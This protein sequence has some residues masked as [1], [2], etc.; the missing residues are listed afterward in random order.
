LTDTSGWGDS[1]AT[2]HPVKGK[3]ADEILSDP[4]MKQRVDAAQ[5]QLAQD[6]PLQIK[7]ISGK[8][9]SEVLQTSGQGVKVAPQ[10]DPLSNYDPNNPNLPKPNT[11]IPLRNLNSAATSGAIPSD[12]T[13]QTMTK[14]DLNNQL[15]IMH[16]DQALTLKQRLFAAGYLGQDAIS[17]DSVPDTPDITADVQKG[18]A[19]LID[20]TAVAN[21]KITD[22]SQ[23]ISLDE[24]LTNKIADQKTNLDNAVRE[25]Y[26]LPTVMENV[27]G[28]AEKMLGRRLTDDE[29]N[30]V[31]NATFNTPQP[32]HRPEDLVVHGGGADSTAIAFGK[33]LAKSYGLTVTQDFSPPSA[34]PSKEFTKGLGVMLGGDPDQ[35]LALHQWANANT[36]DGKLFKVAESITTD[37]LGPV[38]TPEGDSAGNGLTTVG[39]KLVFNDGATKPVISGGNFYDTTDKT[40]DLAKFMAAIRRPGGEAAYNWQG[41][42][43]ARGAYGLSDATWNTYAQKVGVD[44]GNPT[45][46]AQD[47]VARAYIQDLYSG[48]GTD[49][50]YHNWEDVAVAMRANPSIANM[51][52][53]AR[54]AGSPGANFAGVTANTD[55]NVINTPTV[56]ADQ[57]RQTIE[58]QYP[59]V[60]GWARQAVLAMPKVKTQ[61]VNPV[62]QYAAQ[63]GASGYGTGLDSTTAYQG[64]P[65]N[66][67]DAEAI[68][69]RNMQENYKGVGMG[70]AMLHAIIGLM[71]KYTPEEM[72]SMGLKLGIS[73]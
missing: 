54:N 26:H 49:Q 40:D 18:W 35:L 5:Q 28:N 24:M 58:Q 67:Q 30:Q 9:G 22:P 20:D 17:K 13:D 8:D 60:L 47:R 15:G 3:D 41:D 11:D 4:A 6:F 51:N 34:A 33:S 32:G 44:P 36:G 71:A 61:S 27:Q 14:T 38:G 43:H 55:P 16:A 31:I 56:P 53:Q 23:R 64:Q 21:T 63:T 62:D 50:G 52:V 29:M 37:G 65:S 7:E 12:W 48:T 70:G 73:R 1:K 46:D 45:V 57:Q 42:G 59:G 2:L 19:K 72:D 10:P 66:A 25:R 39:L 69:N 68:M